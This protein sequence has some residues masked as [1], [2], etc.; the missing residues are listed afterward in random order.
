MASRFRSSRISRSSP[1]AFRSSLKSVMIGSLR[2]G[3]LTPM[4]RAEYTDEMREA[5]AKELGNQ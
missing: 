3:V 4:Q 5:M 1:F 2:L